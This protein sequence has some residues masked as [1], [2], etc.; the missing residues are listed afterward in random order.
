MK[1]FIAE[2]GKRGVCKKHGKPI[3]GLGMCNTEYRLAWVRR[4]V[5]REANLTEALK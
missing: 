5:G 4:W 1:I 2:K 3:H